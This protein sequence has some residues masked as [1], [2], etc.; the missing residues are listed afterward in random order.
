MHSMQNAHFNEKD[1]S[2]AGRTIVTAPPTPTD[3]FLPSFRIPMARMRLS[4]DAYQ[5]ALDVNSFRDADEFLDAYGSH[6]SNGRQEVPT[7]QINTHC[8]TV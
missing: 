8:M 4:E 6:V 1:V 3:H 2:R 7:I 5:A